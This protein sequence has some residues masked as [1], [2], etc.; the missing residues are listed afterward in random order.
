MPQLTQQSNQQQWVD[1]AAKSLLAVDHDDG[2]AL[3]VTSSELRVGV[4]IDHLDRD[5]MRC[6]QGGRFVTQMTT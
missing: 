1:T 4:D 5:A 2:H 3:I 6:Q